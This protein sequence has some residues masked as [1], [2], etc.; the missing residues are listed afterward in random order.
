MCVRDLQ[1]T[2]NKLIDAFTHTPIQ[3]RTQT[4]AEGSRLYPGY[5]APRPLNFRCPFFA[6][7][8]FR[9][10]AM[11]FYFTDNGQCF[12]IFHEIQTISPLYIVSNLFL[13]Q[14]VKIVTE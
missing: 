2:R 5:T 9:T 3:W 13:A 7:F 4:G 10:P 1:P 11:N 12:L 6:V 14:F 8:F